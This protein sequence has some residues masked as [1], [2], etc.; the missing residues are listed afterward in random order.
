MAPTVSTPNERVHYATQP[1]VG[2]GRALVLAGIAPTK[3]AADRRIAYLK[4]S[5]ARYAPH[6]TPDVRASL[7]RLLDDERPTMPLK[8]A[9]YL[10]AEC[11]AKDNPVAVRLMDQWGDDDATRR[12]LALIEQGAWAAL[13]IVRSARAEKGWA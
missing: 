10:W 11:D 13:D 7:R 2:S 8:A 1:R 5:L 12:N 9:L 6:L 3:N 4:D